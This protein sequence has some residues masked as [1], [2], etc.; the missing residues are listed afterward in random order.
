MVEVEE[1]LIPLVVVLGEA[2][3]ELLGEPLLHLVEDELDGGIHGTGAL[4]ESGKV[5]VRGKGIQD[6]ESGTR[7]LA[8]EERGADQRKSSREEE[9]EFG[10]RTGYSL[11]ELLCLFIHA[12]ALLLLSS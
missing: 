4:L 8:T 6:S 3:A 7:M 1:S 5:I 10:R 9:R 12:G 11:R 2:L